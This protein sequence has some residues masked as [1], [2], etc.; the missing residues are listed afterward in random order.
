MTMP[1]YWNE[2]E[3]KPIRGLLAGAAAGLFASWVMTGFQNAWSKVSEELQSQEDKKSDQQEQSSSGE[4][5]DPTAKVAGKIARAT[6]G[7]NLSKQEK[8]KGGAAVHYAFGTFSGAVYGL[9]SEYVPAARLGFGTAF[10]VLLFL[11]AD[12][13]AVPALG[14]SP[15][16]TETPASSHIYGMASHLVYGASTEA[17]RR[18]IRKVA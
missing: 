6:V 8:Q 17:A 5:E 14:L 10:G 3:S 18:G 16:P 15:K 1:S 11:V 9:L 12:E 7:R 4:S 13:L 2:N